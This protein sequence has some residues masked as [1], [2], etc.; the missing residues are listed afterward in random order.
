[1]TAYLLVAAPVELCRREDVRD[2]AEAME[3][4]GRELDRN[5][6][7]EEEHKHETDGF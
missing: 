6:E 4:H 2:G 3:Q 1:M 5:D 7:S